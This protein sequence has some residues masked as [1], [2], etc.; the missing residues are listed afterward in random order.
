MT[1][2]RQK[3][4][5]HVRQ[6]SYY[7]LRALQRLAC[8]RCL[9]TQPE[10]SVDSFESA[11]SG[12]RNTVLEG[13]LVCRH[14]GI[15]QGWNREYALRLCPSYRTLWNRSA[16]FK[17][18]IPNIKCCWLHCSKFL[19]NIE[20]AEYKY[21]NSPVFNHIERKTIICMQALALVVYTWA[22]NVAIYLF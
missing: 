15:S 6:Q 16:G 7:C 22:E 10:P 14:C 9:R 8:P 1:T 3:Y 11:D 17:A 19:T 18:Q 13:T 12:L 21:K 5:C 2:L 4:K 20:Y